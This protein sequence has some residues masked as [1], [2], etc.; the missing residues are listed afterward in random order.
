MF[1]PLL[2][3]SS[4]RCITRGGYNNKDCEHMCRRKIL[5]FN[6]TWC[7]T[8]IK[9]SYWPVQVHRLFKDRDLKS[10]I[11]LATLWHQLILETEVYVLWR[12]DPCCVSW[13]EDSVNM[14]DPQWQLCIPL[15]FKRAFRC[16]CRRCLWVLMRFFEQ[17]AFISVQAVAVSTCSFNWDLL[18]SVR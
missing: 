14:F 11:L 9:M 18:L 13:F 10:F 5:S 12:Q 1:R 17:T 8:H 2:W 15:K 7:K 6:N 16:V 3:P 4:G